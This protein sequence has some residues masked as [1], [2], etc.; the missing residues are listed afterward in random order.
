MCCS[1]AAQCR[2]YDRT[3][4]HLLV[5]W[6]ALVQELTWEK[7]CAGCRQH[8]FRWAV[9]LDCTEVTEKELAVACHASLWV[10]LMHSCLGASF[11]F[12]LL[13]KCKSAYATLHT[14]QDALRYGAT[15]AP[16]G[17]QRSRSAGGSLP[18]ARAPP[19]RSDSPQL[20]M[21]CGA[22]GSAVAG[23]RAVDHTTA[24]PTK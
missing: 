13:H 18:L 6:T 9:C 20:L 1:C 7:C 16:A 12:H 3:A 24:Q 22:A 10:Q 14:L 23:G 4:T 21:L 8:S 19:R 2:P 15:S 11:A 17:D 5:R